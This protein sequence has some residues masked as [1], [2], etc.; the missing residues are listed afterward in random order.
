MQHKIKNN[1]ESFDIPYQLYLCL[2]IPG[3]EVPR[4]TKAMALTES[5]RLIK[6]PKCPATSPM[7]AVQAPIAD[8]D[9]TN[10][11][12]PSQIANNR[13]YKGTP[14]INYKVC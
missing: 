8:M 2:K 4:A 14:M 12:Y 3:T 9:T 7:I 5:F 1:Q 6:Q 10:V 11:G 13:I